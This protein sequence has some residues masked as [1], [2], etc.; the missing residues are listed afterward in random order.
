MGWR[1]PWVSSGRNEFNY[2]FAV[3]VPGVPAGPSMPEMPRD[4]GEAARDRRYNFTKEPS[5]PE[6]PGLSAFALDDG[7]VYHT[8]SCYGRGLDAFN[9]AYQ[10]LDRAPKGRDEDDLP[11][12]VSWVRRHDEYEHT[13]RVAGEWL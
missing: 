3:S 10:L 6:Q 7:L 2:D 11:G 5:A 8:Y 9:G 13:A 12:P 4:L 1:F